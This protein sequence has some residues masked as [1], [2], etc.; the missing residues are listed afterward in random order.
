VEIDPAKRLEPICLTDRG[1]LRRIRG[2]SATTGLPRHVAERQR[3][4]AVRRIE[5]E[6]KIG[7]EI[8]IL[9]DAPGK[10]QG[11]FFFLVA[12]LDRVRAAF[13]SLGKKGK[14]AEEVAREA[15]DYFK[16]YIESDGCVD[17]HLADQ[18]VPF[19]VLASGNSSFTTTRITEHLS[20]NVWVIRHFLDRQI[21]TS[22]DKG[23]RGRVDFVN[24]SS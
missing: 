9:Y 20:T 15:V 14:P 23:G 22:G 4:Y 6:M 19:M 2:L 8:E 13:S 18:I 1:S 7:A 3:D 10:G 11:S 21:S 24:E 16:E 17:P 5:N 12:E